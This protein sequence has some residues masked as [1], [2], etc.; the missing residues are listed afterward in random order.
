MS[1]LISDQV[2]SLVRQ[3]IDRERLLE[4]ATL[5]VGTPSP[6][7]GEHRCG[8]G[9]SILLAEDLGDGGVT[10]VLC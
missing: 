9:G 3:S 2:V 10:L 6:R 7:T 4:T 8:Q 1:G 5:L